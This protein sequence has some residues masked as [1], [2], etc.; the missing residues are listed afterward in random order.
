MQRL[1][2]PTATLRTKTYKLV[3]VDATGEAAALRERIVALIAAGDPE[4][5]RADDA[6]TI[7]TVEVAQFLTPRTAAIEG[8]YRVSD[9]AE[10]TIAEGSI[11]AGNAGALR[12]LAAP[13]LVEDAAR[14]VAGVLV[15][16]Q[17]ESATAVPRG[18]LDRI[19]AA[20]ERGDWAAYREGIA[21]L[22]VLPG[23]A[24]AARLYALAVAHE[25]AAY[26]SA[27]LAT[28]VSHLREAVEHNVAAARLKPDERLFSEQVMRSVKTPAT[29]PKRWVTPRS[30][31]RWESRLRMRAWLAEAPA[32][33][34]VLNMRGFL[35]L[36]EDGR[37]DAEI[38]DE[39]EQAS[40]VRFSLVQEDMT[41][42]A[43]A[44]VPWRL[45]RAMRTRAG[46]PPPPLHIPA[47]D[48]PVQ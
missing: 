42:L 23:E 32:E 9:L 28:L 11:R 2:P 35:A 36:L 47:D 34:G 45:I 27:D 39:L 21:Q 40:T 17:Y 43:S 16:L 13:A 38:L 46:L 5:R 44:G 25:G 4:L 26:Q 22:T 48:W 18:A 33:E 12:Q 29:P 7:L 20:A 15:P 6:A 41:T 31:E 19:T 10:R 30:M 1:S 8:T 14:D 24:D 3:F 37:T